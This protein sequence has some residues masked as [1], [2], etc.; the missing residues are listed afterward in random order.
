MGM[1]C[2]SELDHDLLHAD[3]S[4]GETE[5]LCQLASLAPLLSSH[6]HGG[7]FGGQA[8]CLLLTHCG[9][10]HLWHLR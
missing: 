6:S 2:V 10:H 3:L 1:L 9:I 5:A 7:V 8:I 4:S